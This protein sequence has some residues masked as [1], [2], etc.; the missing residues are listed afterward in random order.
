MYWKRMTT[1]VLAGLALGWIAPLQAGAC[2]KTTDEGGIG[3]S[4]GYRDLTEGLI[5]TVL[6]GGEPED[7]DRGWLGVRLD[8][9][10]PALA[11]QLDLGKRGLLVVNICEGSPADRAGLQQYDVIVKFG[12]Q[13]VTRD[14]ESLGKRLCELGPNA[15][16]ELVVLRHGAER[17]LSTTLES[18]PRESKWTWRYEDEPEAVFTKEFTL[19]GK[20]VRITSDG[21][22]IVDD[23]PLAVLPHQF[24]DLLPQPYKQ[25]FQ[26]WNEDGRAKLRAYAEEGSC[27]LQ[28]ERDTD[29]H[30]HIRRMNV[31]AGE[32]E[33]EEKE[34]ESEEALREG[35]AGAY[36]VLKE[37]L[38]QQTAAPP[39]PP[40]VAAPTVVPT[41]PATPA[42]LPGVTDASAVLRELQR[43]DDEGKREE[44]LE[45]I[46]PVIRKEQEDRRRAQQQRMRERWSSSPQYS[47]EVASDGS[48]TTVKRKGDSELRLT[49]RSAGEMEKKNPALYD[50]YRSL[51]A[52]E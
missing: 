38:R 16:V 3:P 24:R 19:S 2:D 44:L 11:A 25:T 22:V 41:P 23:V 35:D 43:R 8:Q 13:E 4:G 26:V 15:P 51:Q 36:E 46:A 29:E 33:F 52:S 9:P 31:A 39:Q 45:G 14:H 40:E 20:I 5:L 50:R 42:P 1:C 6:L 47:F 10:G 30:I 34:Y 49:F 37:Y 18:R 12:G 27:I 17:S 28:I 32:D 7:S 48:V 21:A